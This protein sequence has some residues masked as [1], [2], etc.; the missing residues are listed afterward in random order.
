MGWLSKIFRIK[1]APLPAF[2]YLT[3]DGDMFYPRDL[4]RLM[5]RRERID[6]DMRRTEDKEAACAVCTPL[7]DV[8]DKLG[9]M[10]ARAQVYVV[11]EDNNERRE[12]ENVRSLLAAPNPLQDFS[13][14]VKTLEM[15]LRLHGFAVVSFVRGMSASV[16]NAMWMLPPALLKI[17][18][19][20]KVLSQYERDEVIDRVCVRI[21]GNER[22]L[23]DYVIIST[24]RPLLP[25]YKDGLIHYAT[26]TDALSMP[27]NNWIASQI[28]ASS[29]LKNGGPKGILHGE[30]VDSFGQPALT[31]PD[32]EE[33]REQFKRKYGLVGQKYPILV[34]RHRLQ[35][36]PLDFNAAQLRLGETDKDCAARICNALGVNQNLFTDAKYDNQE[37]AKK[38][39]YQDVIIPDA[40]TIAARLTE[41]LLP[42]GGRIML[43]YSGVECLQ[44]SKRDEAQTLQGVAS[45]LQSLVGGGLISQEEARMCLS[46]YMDINP[47]DKV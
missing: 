47:N 21:D 5:G 24:G 35:W 15:T 36:Q 39:A 11:D 40:N 6:F 1:S 22:V 37:S 44:G 27:V 45:S 31:K 30:S 4:F 13:A 25:L 12:Y 2:P 19:T 17:Y 3:E 41:A 32:E 18:G 16:P 8:L 38:S 43:D 20:G 10:A 28:A 7:F 9:S 42:K 14:F 26:P 33:I 29:L 46:N 23:D 34:T